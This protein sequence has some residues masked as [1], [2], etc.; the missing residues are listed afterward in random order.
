MTRRAVNSSAYHVPV[1]GF[2]QMVATSASGTLLFVSGIT[3]RDVDGTILHVG[4][5][6]GQT[7]QI[8][9][10]M[11]AILAEA[12]ATLD[13]VVQIHTFM[14]DIERFGEVKTVWDDYWGGTY[15]ASTAVQ[16]SRLWDERQLIEM[17]AVAVVA[18][19]V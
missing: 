2:T 4:D 12:G 1:D 14:R 3:S 10:Q 7:R 19:E 16:I 5:Y 8:L 11:T 15:P 6:A 18:H 17:D 9:G 13:D